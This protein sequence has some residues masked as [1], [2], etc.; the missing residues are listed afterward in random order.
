MPTT[1]S[2]SNMKYRMVAF[3]LDGTLLGPDHQISD[4][5][6]KYLRSLHNKGFLISIATGRSAA[7]TAQVIR[8]LNLEFPKSH[9]HAFPLVTTNGARGIHVFHDRTTFHND[10]ISSSN[11][12]TVC[13]EDDN[14]GEEEKKQAVDGN[15]MVDGRMRITELFHLPVPMDLTVK[16]LNLAKSIGCVTNYYIDHDIYAHVV[17]NW[18]MDATKNY[19][20]LTGVDYI[21]CQDDYK[22]AM[23]RGRPS[24]LLVLCQPK[25]IDE[26][27]KKLEDS[28]GHEAKV[29]RGSPPFFVEV[30][31]KHVNKGTGLE[32]LCEKLGIGIHE[33]ISFGDGDNDIEFIQKS[34]LGVAMKNARD[35]VKEH[36]DAV[37]EHTNVDDGAIRMLQRLESEGMLHF[38]SV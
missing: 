28:L 32:L 6:V 5:S 9:S 25:S 34:G 20:H 19:S 14:D 16:T 4:Y 24:K 27:Y 18:H 1:S 21:Y 8:R 30:L 23:D 7:A 13:D 22:Q 38:S 12:S 35:A 11:S 3:D 17:E 33:C 36:A 37:T 2:N 26:I 10:G 29:I 15:P 31:N